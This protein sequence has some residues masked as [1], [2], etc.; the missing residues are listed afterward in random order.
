MKNTTLT[1]QVSKISLDSF[2]GSG[3]KVSKLPNKWEHCWRQQSRQHL[4][5]RLS[6]TGDSIVYGE[7]CQHLTSVVAWV[8]VEDLGYCATSI[9]L[10][11]CEFPCCYYLQ[12][13]LESWV[14]SLATSCLCSWRSKQFGLGLE[15]ELST[16][17]YISVYHVGP[18]EPELILYQWPPLNFI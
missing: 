8:K 5:S 2:R 16:D 15:T 3:T 10:F 4:H 17:S 6:L 18:M 11:S 7:D 12:E 9:G 13:L 14:I 1:H